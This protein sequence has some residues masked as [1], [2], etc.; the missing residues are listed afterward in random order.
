MK[1]IINNPNDVVKEALEGMQMAYKDKLEYVPGFELIVRKELKNKVGIISGGGSG[2]EPLH[3]GYVGEGMLDAAV[4]GNIF[5]SPS[6]DRISEAIERVDKGEGVLLV[7]KNY[8]GDIM[9][10]GL[11]KDMAEADDKK[12]ATVIVKDDVAVEDSTYSTGR[13]GIAGTV[14]V[15][16]IAGAMAEKGAS[17]EEVERAANK[18]IANIRSM[19]MAMSACTLPA[20]GKP[21]FVLAENEM[22]VGMGIHG[23]PGI[24]RTS[25]K[26]AKETAKTLL[27]KI[28]KDYDY[29]N[30][31]V[32]L[33]VNGLGATPLMELYILN[34]EVCNLLEEKNIKVYKN[35]VGNYTTALDMSGCSLTLMKL[36]NELKELL[37]APCD[38]PAWKNC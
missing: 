38:T 3:A 4:A 12:V 20:V 22:E 36:D 9:N 18:A 26:S 15:H 13:R 19:G 32:A 34:R 33:L 1:K 2:H 35:M 16:K 14:F 37:D 17:L 25:I 10:F 7:I 11:S 29:S 8:S 5:S 24:E 27:E 30:S 28:L 23:E 6:P 21:G 31:E